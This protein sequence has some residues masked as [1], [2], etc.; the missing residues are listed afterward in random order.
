MKQKSL[1]IGNLVSLLEERCPPECAEEW[2]NVG[3]LVG[4]SEQEVRSVVLCIDLTLEAIQLAQEQECS[5]IITHHPCLFPRRAHASAWIQGS[6][7]YQAIQQKIAVAAFH[8]NF[9]QCALEVNDQI[10]YQLGLTLK[11]RLID[12]VDL[13]KLSVFVPITHLDKVRQ[14]VGEAGGG[15][16]GKYD[17]CSFA[18]LGEGCFRPSP[19][20]Q[21]FLGKVNQLEKVQEYRLEVVFPK[22]LKSKVLNAL[23]E[24]HPYEEIAYDLYSIYPNESIH[25]SMQAGLGYGFWGDFSSAK[26]FSEFA[27]MIKKL[28][29]VSGFLMTRPVPSFVSRMGFVA[30]K[31]SRLLKSALHNQCHVFITGEV[32]YHLARENAQKGMTV[33]ELGHYE[34]ELFFIKT[35]KSWLLEVGVKCI[36]TKNSTQMIWIGGE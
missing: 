23:R 24:S 26:T 31:G 9:D 34:S 16:I 12:Q 22:G 15:R 10:S 32:G 4:D 20:A 7:V 1:T 11:G 14:A 28:F 36:E 13:L 6:L 25:K 18:S 3:L 29:S 2:D 5:L 35:M 21:P 17:F 33:I 8:T 27:Q 30:G 19:F